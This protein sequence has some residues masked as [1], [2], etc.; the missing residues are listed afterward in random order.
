MTTLLRRF[1]L[2]HLVGQSVIPAVFTAIGVFTFV[3]G[4]LY[5]PSLAPTRIE[6]FLFMLLLAVF[7]VLCATFA[8]LVVVAKRL[9]V[10]AGRRADTGE[11]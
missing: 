6:S 8:Q 5:L 9:E 2:T 1:F 3:A 10:R 11:R 7:A 4:I